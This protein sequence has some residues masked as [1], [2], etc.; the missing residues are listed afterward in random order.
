[1][2]LVAFDTARLADVHISQDHSGAEEVAVEVRLRTERAGPAERSKLTAA[3]TLLDGEAPVARDRP[4]LSRGRGSATLRV[5]NPEL[6]WPNGMGQQPLYTLRIELCDGAGELLDVQTRRIG[7]RTLELVRQ[8]DAWGESFGFAANGIPFFAKGANWIPADAILTR[9]ETRDYRRILGDAAAAHM[10][11]LRVWGGG[12]YE[13]DL[14][15]DLC[16]EL[17]ICVWQDFMF[18]CATY[19]THR[20]AFLDNVRAEAEDN[21]TRLRHHACLTLWCGNNELEMGLVADA[22]SDWTMSWDDYRRLFDDLL[23]GVVEELDPET[24]YWPGSPHTPGPGESR[25]NANHPARGDAHLWG[26]WHGGEPFEWYRGCQH[27]FNSEFGFQSFPEPRTVEGFTKAADRNLTSPVMEHHQ[28]SGIGN[29]TIVRYMLEWFR[30]PSSFEKTLW[31]SQ[32]LQGLAVQ[33]AVEHWRRGMP[34]GMGTL[35][36]QLN[37]CWP[38]ASWSSIDFRGRWKALHYLARR[39]YAPVLVSGVEDAT[40]GKLAIHVTSDLL[41]SCSGRLRWAVT[42]VGGKRIAGGSRDLRIAPGRSRRVQSLD[43]RP[44]LK[45]YG[46]RDLLVWLELTGDGPIQSS[47]LVTFARPKAMELRDPRIGWT[48]DR[49]PGGA[50]ELRLGA[51]YPALWTWVEA[52]GCDL[53]LSDNFFHLRPGR[54]KKLALR[55]ETPLSLAQLRRG[56]RVQSLVDTYQDRE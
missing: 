6:W 32:I 48:L 8:R 7:L 25:R 26:V 22:W 5:K 49:A 3:V 33:Y 35:Y 24:A 23:P 41:K 1:V 40:L 9:F 37:D 20:R 14:F 11:M 15:Y 17:G 43:L 12:I 29:T 4:R 18:A 2:E 34:R 55:P 31:L 27:R 10:N 56:L 30:M 13:E 44:M 51:R 19:P 38:V 47:N 39:F 36:W 45:E 53:R 52:E 16:D 28:R 42:R 46:D 21:V 54:S 50:F